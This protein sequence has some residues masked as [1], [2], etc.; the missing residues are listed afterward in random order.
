MAKRYDDRHRLLKTGERQRSSGTYEYRW[1]SRNGKNHSISAETLE[2]LRKKEEDI[3][4]DKSDGILVGA[5]NVKL[6]DIYGL[7]CHL[8][9]GLADNT[10]QNYK[11][12]YEMFVQPKIGQIR[13]K[14]L[15]RSD[16]K[17]LYN[18]LLEERGLKVNTID[19]VHTVLHQVLTVAVEENYIRI[20]IAD[21]IL[22]ELKQSHNIEAPHRKA[23]TVAEQE[24]FIGYLKRENVKYHHWYPVFEVMVE[25]GMRVGEVTGLRWEDVDFNSDLISVNHTLVYYDHR[26]DGKNSCYFNVHPTKTKAGTRTIPMLPGVKEALLMEKA[27]QEFNQI[28]CR[29]TVDGFTDFIFIN[30]YGDCQHQGTLNKALRRIIRDCNDEQLDKFKN[31]VLLPRFSCH[32]LRHT[33]TTR[34]FENGVNIKV[35]QEIL[36]HADFD[37]TMNIYTHITQDMKKSEFDNF[38]EKLQKQRETSQPKTEADG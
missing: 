22:K 36:G 28:K 26:V 24:L 9:R 38:A 3:L 15:K 2:E 17:S 5:E 25:T 30:R 35:I 33:F 7:W 34:L 18:Y 8:K 6:D 11:Y 32:S 1:T 13:I 16:V 4:K 27:Y 14:Q 37:T 20:N 23:L 29:M 31:P 19:G 10:F 12:L 21:N